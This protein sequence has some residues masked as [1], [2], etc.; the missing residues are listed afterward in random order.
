MKKLLILLFSMLIS[1]NSY[2]KT[3]CDLTDALLFENE[4]L[5]VPSETKPFTGENQYDLYR[6]ASF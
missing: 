5:F 6:S 4:L 1:F 2:G 3:V